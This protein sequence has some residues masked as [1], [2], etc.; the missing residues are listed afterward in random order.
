M[1][2]AVR[3]CERSTRAQL[4]AW[5]DAWAAHLQ[6]DAPAP[7]VPYTVRRRVPGAAGRPPYACTASSFVAWCLG[8][9]VEAPMTT[10][11]R[12]A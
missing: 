8:E 9:P 12:A 2:H 1:P 10:T 5:H 3:R 11:A 4:K 7:E 6:G